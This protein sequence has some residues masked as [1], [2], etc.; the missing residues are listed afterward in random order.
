[1]EIHDE[2]ALKHQTDIQISTLYLA[3][4]G[5]FKCPQNSDNTVC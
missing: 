4:G 2:T 5:K 1:M 3:P